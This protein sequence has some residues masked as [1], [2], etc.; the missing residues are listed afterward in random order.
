MK[1][2]AYHAALQ[3]AASSA[4]QTASLRS[5]G[6][7]AKGVEVDEAAGVIKGAALMVIGDAEGHGFSIDAKT[8]EQVAALI[9]REPNGVKSRFKHPQIPEPGEMMPD[10][11]GDVI[12]RVKNARID[13]DTLRGDV[14]LGEY[15]KM[16]PG[17]GDVRSYL[18]SRAKEDPSGF[19]LSA[20]IRFDVEPAISG[21]RP[22]ILV[23]R[24]DDVEAVDFVGRGA[25]TPRG[26]LSAQPVTPAVV[27]PTPQ[28]KSKPRPLSAGAN[29]GALKMNPKMKQYL[30]ANHGLAADATDD[31]AQEMF[32]GLSADD[33]AKCNASMAAKTPENA[34]PAVALAGRTRVEAGDEFL[35]LEGRRVAQLRQLGETLGV[36]NTVIQMAIASAD[37]VPKA[38]TR[39]LTHLQ[40][41]CKPV[42]G[43][44][45]NV[46][47]D[48]N[49][50]SLAA[51]IPD[52]IR[53]RAGLT[54][55]KPHERAQQLRHRSLA[56]MARTFFVS[57][58]MPTDEVYNLSP[59]HIAELLGPRNFARKY[60]R[61]AQLAQSSSDF[62]SILAD[63]INKTLRNAY[64]DAP[65]TWN[66]WARRTTN[67][68]FKTITRAA[69][70]ESPDLVSR[71]EGKGINYVTLSDSKETYALTEY[72]G[73]I[74]LTRRAI[75]NDD[76]DAFSRIPMLQGNAAKRKEDDVAYAII[77][78]NAAMADTGTLFNATAVTTTGGH[79]NYTSSGLAVTVASLAAQEKLLKKQK[80]P[81]GASRLELQA[82]FLLVPSSIYRVA[83]QVVS[84][85]VDPAKNNAAVNPFMNEGL[86]IV[87]SARLDDNSAT[88]WYLF[89]DY[90]AGQVDTIEVCFLA[91][92]P[93][94]VAKQETD[95]DTEDAKFAIRHTVAA[96]A[97][98]F[99]GMT[100]Q[101]G[102]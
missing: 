88:A 29:T 31:Q 84:S 47:V 80:G 57:L 59:V 58:G 3:A 41:K 55:E 4:L 9:N 91:D 99:R 74:K 81:A 87:S 93:E 90:R 36:D 52:A 23:A 49:R 95:F 24:V 73:G 22:D 32:D 63:T 19:G 76:L 10:D 7:F 69:L 14:Y 102:A 94:P 62:T 71:D 67:P 50:A 82:K 97:I 30:S 61:Y 28:T 2:I 89:A 33:Q 39:Y 65:S 54:V 16:L 42:E 34:T 68:D 79:D 46:G 101:A 60:P 64:L 70:S 92:E 43:L 12:G 45:V 35:A 40:E 8:L 1:P 56:D 100:K 6:A 38:R 85:T 27:V 96:K 25:A 44:S 98:D 48:N 53:L 21:G 78:A 18:I 75:I 66:I 20:V 11:L 15:A 72:I 86:V 83:Q 5:S 51:A 77:T 13:G 37:D 26:L 17:L